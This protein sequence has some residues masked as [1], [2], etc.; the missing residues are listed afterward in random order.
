LPPYGTDPAWGGRSRDVLAAA[1]VLILALSTLVLSVDNQRRI[2]SGLQQSALRPFIGVQRRLGDARV[3]A[4]QVD[5]MLAVVDSLSAMLSTHAA[6]VEENSTLRGLLDLSERTVPTY[7][8][9]TLLRPG[10]PGAESMFIVDVGSDDGVT[11]GSPVVGPFGLVGVVR[12]V[13]DREAVGIDWTHPDFRASAM[14]TDGSAFGLIEN[15]PGRFR[16]EDRLVLNGIPFNSKIDPE[17]VVVTSGLGGVFPRGIPVGRIDGLA[18]SQGEWRKSY[19][20]DPMVFP[21]SATHVLVIT[22]EASEAAPGA[23]PVGPADSTRA[24][25]GDAA[26]VEGGS[27]G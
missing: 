2:A 18:D 5:S 17:A 23:W 11:A 25:D 19:W 16:E 12:E 6:L 3:R 13:R 8:P 1:V 9:A 20:L 26:G 22:G 10:T 24:S 27:R 4:A 15:R 14:V 7:L 21:A